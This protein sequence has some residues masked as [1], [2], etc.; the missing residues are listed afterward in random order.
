[1][2]SSDLLGWVPRT[3]MEA[4]W[5]QLDVMVLPSLTDGKKWVEQFGRVLVEAMA[6]GVPVVGSDAGRIP[7]TVG[8][9]GLIFHEGNAAGLQQALDALRTSPERREE[10]REKGLARVRE[11][12]S[13]DVLMGRT[14]RFYEQVLESRRIETRSAAQHGGTAQPETG[15]T[16]R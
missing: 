1:V 6:A 9:A 15:Q 4:F 5:S 10:L 7:D 14:V 2:C 16:E 11:H 12:Y 13:H 8:D 3:D